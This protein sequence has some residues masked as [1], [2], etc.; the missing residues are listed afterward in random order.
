M[1]EECSNNPVAL[2]VGLADRLRMYFDE[3][4]VQVGLTPAQGHALMAIEGP[5]RMGDLAAQ[6]TCDPSSVTS[7]IGRL[8]RDGFVQRVVDPHD[9]R[10]RL[11]QLSRK[12]ATT[13]TRLAGLLAGASSVIDEL[14]V[15]HRAALATLFAQRT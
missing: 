8:E 13:R 7:M 1:S 11:V 15:E 4:A 6:Q 3:C 12:G 9:A 2:L 5:T 10:A 14:P